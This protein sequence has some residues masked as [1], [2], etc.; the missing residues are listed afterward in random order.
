MPADHAG[1]FPQ[2]VTVQRRAIVNSG[3][4]PVPGEPTVIYEDAPAGIAIA[5][6]GRMQ[7]VFSA[8]VMAVASHI[9]RMRPLGVRIGD[10][11]VWTDVESG[12][13]SERVLRVEGK[14]Q[15]ERK[16]GILLAV[17]EIVTS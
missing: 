12:E 10:E 15:D 16:R 5:S 11:L 8:Q 9:V 14:H 7:E 17:R 2:R 4:V 3:G 1:S 13:E 6:P